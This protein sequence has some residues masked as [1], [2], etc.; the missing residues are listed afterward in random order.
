MLIPSLLRIMLTRSFQPFTFRGEQQIELEF[1]TIE[2]LGL[3]LHIPFC[4]S[5]CSFCPY[6]KVI[7]DEQLAEQYKAALLKEID[8]VGSQL[9]MKKPVTSL[10]IGGGTPALMAGSLKEIIDCIRKY[11][12]LE[13]GIAVELH[14]DDLTPRIIALLQ[15]AGVTMIS[16]GIQSFNRQCL[17]A[18][19]RAENDYS[20]AIEL[21]KQ[22][23]FEVIDIDLIFAIPGQTK[24]ML[25]N[26]IDT[27]FN[28]GATQVS[29]YPFIEFSFNRNSCKPLS[30]GDKKRMLRAIAECCEESGRERTSVWTFALSGTAKY[31]SVTRDHFLGFGPSATTLLDKKF[32]I[33]TFSI[34][35]YIEKVHSGQLPTSLSLS[36]T[37]RQRAAY[38]LF[39]SAYAMKIDPVHFEKIVGRPLSELFGFELWIAQKL[40]LLY[41]K[42]GC[43][44][45]TTRGALYYH[46]IEQA[47][48]HAYIS[49]T[50]DIC[51]A[52]PFPQKSRSNPVTGL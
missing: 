7:Y 24:Q 50:R 4:H 41:M 22:S 52:N 31:S 6:N 32:K 47:Y 45:L 34:E 49:K 36:F 29:T 2:D 48:T 27:A 10:Y 17:A 14:P 44:Y 19:G 43:Y 33:N 26:D 38:Y 40:S 51:R 30:A 25:L 18:L 28:L 16:V 42:K 8:L 11:F 23:G 13:H 1:A 46:F 37:L 5:L 35:A 9:K 3:Y 20:Q 39:W 21:L 12:I 15:E